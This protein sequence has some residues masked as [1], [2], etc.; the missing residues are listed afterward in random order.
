MQFANIAGK[1]KN[2][3]DDLEDLFADKARQNVDD[4]EVE[5][6][7][8]DRAIREH[9]HME[10]ALDSC[11]RCF[12]ASKFEKQLIV[13]MGK[14]VYVSLP[15]HEGLQPGKYHSKRRKIDFCSE[16]LIFSWKIRILLKKNSFSL[17]NLNFPRKNWI[18]LKKIE[19]SLKNL[20]FP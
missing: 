11:D 16:N 3:N 19:S 13:S 4:R 14:N 18:F 2:P 8:R 6:K 12:E 9:Q 15:W 10:K 1:H 20:N 7:E 17:E 5:R